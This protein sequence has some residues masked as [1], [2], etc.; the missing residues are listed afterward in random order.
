MCWGPRGPLRSTLT[1]SLHTPAMAT[2]RSRWA[3][4]LPRT[5]H[6][7]LNLTRR[8]TNT[9]CRYI[10]GAIW[11]FKNYSSNFGEDGLKELNAIASKHVITM[12]VDDAKRFTYGGVDVHE[13]TL[14]VLF[15]PG[16]LGTNVDYACEKD[17]LMKALNEAPAAAEGESNALSFAVRTG[18]RQDY[19]SKIEEL[20]GK[21]AELVAEPNIKLNPNFEECFAKLKEESKVKKTE[22]RGDWE[23]MMGR[24]AFEYFEGLH[25]QLQWQKF[26]DDEMIQEGFKE[27]VDKNEVIF[28]IV[29][30]LTDDSYGEC[31]VEGG[32]LYLQVSSCCLCS[33]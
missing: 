10:K 5:C 27:A 15:A 16:N 4:A 3:A 1:R 8:A 19:D 2:P 9:G 31:Q 17:T 28:R 12:D 23:S 11:Q 29:E 24:V 13:G 22:L 33:V 21:I 26:E 14:R 20:R 7:T 32:F 6:T 30:K 25:T 18:I